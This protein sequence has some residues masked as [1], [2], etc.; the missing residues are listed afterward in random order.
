MTVKHVVDNAPRYI[1]AGCRV[2]YGTPPK[3][4]NGYCDAC[5]GVWLATCALGVQRERVER[6]RAFVASCADRGVKP[7]VYR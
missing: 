3:T 5:F 6:N 7:V 4:V 2:L 1:C